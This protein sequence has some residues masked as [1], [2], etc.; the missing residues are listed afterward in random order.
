[1][2]PSDKQISG[3]IAQ[4]YAPRLEAYDEMY[5]G[6]GKILPHWRV[7]MQELDELGREGLERRHLEA[8]R[9]LRENGV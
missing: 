4:F 9:L 8:Q 1:M 6:E 2:E 3:S 7:L 5:A